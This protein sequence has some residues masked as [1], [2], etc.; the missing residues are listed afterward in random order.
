MLA[1]PFVEGYENYMRCLQGG[2]RGNSRKLKRQ[3]KFILSVYHCP[4]SGV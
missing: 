1:G 3:I 2:G 4:K